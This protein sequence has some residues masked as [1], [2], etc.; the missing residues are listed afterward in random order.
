MT[1]QL[2]AED[3][4]IRLNLFGFSLAKLESIL[5]SGDLDLVARL[6]VALMESEDDLGELPEVIAETG[7]IIAEAIAKGAPL[8]SLVIEGD[9][10]V[11]AACLLAEHDQDFTPTGSDSWQAGAYWT[12]AQQFGEE[13]EPE[14]RKMLGYFCEGRPLFGKVIDT[15]NKYYGYLTAAELVFLKLELVQLE[16]Y[17]KDWEEAGTLEFLRDLITWLHTVAEAEQDL[18]FYTW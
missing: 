3:L 16:E 11:L 1:E 10:H 7:K 18:W 14:S 2:L 8:N 15:D 6:K 5:A 12:L 9:A 13:L 17:V 4:S